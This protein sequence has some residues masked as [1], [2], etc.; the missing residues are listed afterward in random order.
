MTEVAVTDGDRVDLVVEHPKD[1]S[2]ERFAVAIDVPSLALSTLR[3]WHDGGARLLLIVPPGSN[4]VRFRRL[5]T[6]E[7]LTLHR[8]AD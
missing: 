4:L 6:V 5:D 7:A 1:A 2:C 8:F 3:R